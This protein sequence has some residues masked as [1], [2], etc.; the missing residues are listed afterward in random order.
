MITS[1]NYFQSW[2]CQLWYK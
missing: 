2:L 1:Y